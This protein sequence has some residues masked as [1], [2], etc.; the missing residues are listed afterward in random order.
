MSDDTTAIK[1]ESAGVPPIWKKEFMTIEGTKSF[2]QHSTGFVSG[3]FE[4]KGQSML[5]Y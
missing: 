1:L 4:D 5:I 2:I 3:R